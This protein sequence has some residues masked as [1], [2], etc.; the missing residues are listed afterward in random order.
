MFIPERTLVPE[1]CDPWLQ[2]H[3]CRG[4]TLFARGI[5]LSVLATLNSLFIS[6]LSSLNIFTI[7]ILSYYPVLQLYCS[8]QGLCAE[9]LLASGE[10]MLSWIF[11]ILFFCAGIL[12][13]EVMVFLGAYIWSWFY[14]VGIPF[15][16]CPLWLLVKCGDCRIPGRECFCRS[17]SDT[18]KERWTSRKDW[19]GQKEKSRGA[20]ICTKIWSHQGLEAGWDG[21]SYRQATAGLRLSLERIEW[22]EEG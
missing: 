14:W 7:V 2:I 8:Y 22:V 21:V 5:H 10:G 9:G 11:M 13:F 19:E 6:S 17:T 12:V 20:R 1:C 4:L 3:R 16:D 18:K 15:F